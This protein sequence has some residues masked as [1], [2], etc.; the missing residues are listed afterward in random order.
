LTRLAEDSVVDG[1]YRVLRRLGSGGM[2]DVWCAQDQQLDRKVALKVLHDRFAQDHE[3]VERFRREASAAAGLQHPNV[4]GIYDRGEVD[5]T[6]YIA[7]QYVEGASLK[8]LIE[9]GLSVSAAVGV[10][11]QVLEAT[12]FAHEH[13]IVHRDL[14]PHNILVNREG[15]ATVADFGIARAGH[16]E[17][18][19]TG[20]VMGTAHYLSPEQAQGLDVTPASDLYSIGV[21]LYEALTGRV[22]FEGDSAVAVALKQVSEQPQPPSRL[23]HEVS[24]ALDS[25]VLKALAKDPSNRFSSADE[26]LSALEAAKLNPDQPIGETQAFAAVTPAPVGAEDEAAVA[27]DA[28]P[29]P[30]PPGVSPDARRR[31]WRWVALAALGLLLGGL[32]AWALTRP[33]QVRIPDVVQPGID[34]DQATLELQDAG[35]EVVQTGRP[36]SQP[37]GQ[38]LETDPPAGEEVDEGSTVEVFFSEGLGQARV[39]NVV[40]LQR[41][42]ATR[43]L[44]EEEFGVTVQQRA[45]SEVDEGIV[46]ASRP[47]AGTQLDLGRTVRLIVS[48]GPNLV[49]VPDVVGASEASARAELEQAGFIVNV[50]TAESDQGEGTVIDQSPDG[51]EEAERN[52]G[53][54]IVVSEGPAEPETV[55]VPSVEGLRQDRAT[56]ALTG[57][58]FDVSIDEV[59]TSDPDEDGIVLDQFPSGGTEADPGTQVTIQVGSFVE[60]ESTDEP[61]P[62]PG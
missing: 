34:V 46:I 13:G 41:D 9:R 14:K 39:P 19:Q 60:P 1:R 28:P 7:M 61:Q 43:V 29:I 4:V 44:R 35:F 12:R 52:T 8:Q 17:I 11:R 33:E 15:R 20:S 38:V 42:E 58:G 25:V 37:E 27:S 21:M 2:A 50:D 40:G 45:S 55:A 18:T 59:E 54:T 51:G 16:S 62:V 56:A 6:Y 57:D 49:A 47:P 31:R 48:T 32:A 23:N 36:A 22:P 10:I 26:F 53:V 5:G 30:P 24:P 3:F